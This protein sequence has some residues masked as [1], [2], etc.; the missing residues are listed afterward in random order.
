MSEEKSLLEDLM[1]VFDDIG[2]YSDPV[3]IGVDC[4]LVE[5]EITDTTRWGIVH[6]AVFQRKT[7]IRRNP[8]EFRDE[9]VMV[10]YQEPATEEQDWESFGE[11]TCFPVEPYEVTTTAWRPV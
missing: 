4:V 10:E 2:Y 6:N 7:I 8:I 1:A 9:Y 3:D 5:D 11:P